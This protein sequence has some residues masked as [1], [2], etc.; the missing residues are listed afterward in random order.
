MQR[1]EREIDMFFVRSAYAKYD[2][3]TFIL[4]F[5]LIIFSYK[6]YMCVCRSGNCSGN[7]KTI[8]NIHLPLWVDVVVIAFYE[9]C[10][11]ERTRIKA[12]RQQAI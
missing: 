7:Y 10:P 8:K 1:G 5:I 3:C 4:I 11:L 6:N 12:F 9:V 2:R